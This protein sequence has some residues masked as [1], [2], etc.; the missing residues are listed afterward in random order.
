MWTKEAWT[1]GGKAMQAMAKPIEYEV[2]ERGCHIC[3]S[4][5]PG[6][7]GYPQIRRNKKLYVLVRWLWEQKNYPLGDLVL[8]HTCDTPQC[9]NLDHVESGLHWDNVQDRVQRDR[10]AFGTRNG[11]SKLTPEQVVEIR[12]L[13]GFETAYRVAKCYGVDRKLIVNIWAGKIW[14]RV[15]E[16]LDKLAPVC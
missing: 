7:D 2:N 15:E 11:R 6:R 12:T 10:S 1:A 4:H 8:R 3:T 13:E 16:E 9:I 5:A 14:K